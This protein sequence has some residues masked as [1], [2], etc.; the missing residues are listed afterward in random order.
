MVVAEAVA[1]VAAVAVEVVE[2]VVV[3]LSGQWR[4][5]NN[6]VLLRNTLL[7]FFWENEDMPKDSFLAAVA[8]VLSKNTHRSC[9]VAVRTRSVQEGQ[10]C[11]LLDEWPVLTLPE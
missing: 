11:L 9:W 7:R 1:P 6:P 4:S 10:E 3:A 2:E 5:I 8:S